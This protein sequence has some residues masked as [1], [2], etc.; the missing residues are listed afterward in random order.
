M[1]PTQSKQKIKC[2][3]RYHTYALYLV[4]ILK[5]MILNKAVIFH[6]GVIF[7]VCYPNSN[8]GKDE[9]KQGEK[10]EGK[11]LEFR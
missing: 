11:R 10:K 9:M 8:Y 4:Q 5:K 6:I 1:V 2:L 3:Y 7:S